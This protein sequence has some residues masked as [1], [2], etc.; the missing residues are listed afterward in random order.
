MLLTVDGEKV[1]LANR[2]T[3]PMEKLFLQ[4]QER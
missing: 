1:A 3:F 2:S 4:K